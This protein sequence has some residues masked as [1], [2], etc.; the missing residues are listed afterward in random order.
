MKSLKGVP[1]QDASLRGQ[2]NIGGRNS[3]REG[4][5]NEIFCFTILHE[6]VPPK[7]GQQYTGVG[8]KTRVQT[9][10]EL[11]E[12]L[13]S[14]NYVSS[15][16]GGRCGLGCCTKT[17]PHCQSEMLDTR[18]RQYP[19]GD[20]FHHGTSAVCC[21]LCDQR[22]LPEVHFVNLGS[23]WDELHRKKHLCKRTSQRGI[24]NTVVACQDHYI[25]PPY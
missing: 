1:G 7:R 9:C 19:L 13:G 14:L 6:D 24:C 16:M 10:R 12:N 18:R 21:L 15:R 2:R 23:D 17:R 25:T 11:N 5:A 22:V 3:N 8:W 20:Q 4:S